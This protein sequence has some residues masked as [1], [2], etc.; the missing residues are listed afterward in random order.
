MTFIMFLQ[1]VTKTAQ[2]GLKIELIISM[3]KSYAPLFL[4]PVGTANSKQKTAQKKV[5]FLLNTA[6]F[7]VKTGVKNSYAPRSRLLG[8]FV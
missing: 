6:H 7:S 8:I 4:S 1:R 3:P 5:V 2:K